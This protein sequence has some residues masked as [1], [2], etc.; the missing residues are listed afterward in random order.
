MGSKALA[1]MTPQA[2]GCPLT[3]QW[4][5]GLWGDVIRNPGGGVERG[6]VASLPSG[7]PAQPGSRASAWMDF[8]NS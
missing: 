3:S 1:W 6:S 5:G 8:P 4:G 7:A 2:G